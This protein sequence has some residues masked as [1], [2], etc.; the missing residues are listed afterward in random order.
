[1]SSTR[2]TLTRN[3]A[4]L[5][6]SCLVAGG[7]AVFDPASTHSDK[8]MLAPTDVIEVS[9]WTLADY[10]CGAALLVCEDYVTKLRCQCRKS[11]VAVP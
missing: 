7:C 6:T 2:T 9:R 3:A 10:S 4:V 1:M 5:L 11:M 8:I